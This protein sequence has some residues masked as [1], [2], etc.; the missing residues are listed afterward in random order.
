MRIVET[1][2]EARHQRNAAIS[3]GDRLGLVIATGHLDDHVGAALQVARAQCDLVVLAVRPPLPTDARVPRLLRMGQPN[4][5]GEQ[6]R[7]RARTAGVDLCWLLDPSDTLAAPVAGTGT[8]VRAGAD[9]TRV[10]TVASSA[11]LDE[12]VTTTVKL[13]AALAPQVLYVPEHDFVAASAMRAAIEDLLF[14][15]DVR[16]VATEHRDA[17]VARAFDAARRLVE[18]GEQATG[19]I[20]ARTE[21]EFASSPYA[22]D[23]VAV[24]DPATLAPVP[25]LDGPAQLVIAVRDGA[26]RIT[27]SIALA[28]LSTTVA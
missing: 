5:F 27:D 14:D 22:V 21:V 16:F 1:V 17:Q 7:L 8:A 10:A 4:F 12:L 19:R 20:V 3:R 2:A 6:D 18:D 26:T 11:R 23:Y 25:R 13:L 9:F 24:V 28:G 15:V